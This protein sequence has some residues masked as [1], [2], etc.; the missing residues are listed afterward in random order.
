MY[1]VRSNTTRTVLINQKV[2]MLAGYLFLRFLNI[3]SIDPHTLFTALIP[4][5]EGGGEL[6]FADGTDDPFPG[7]FQGLSAQCEASQLLFHFPAQEK[8]RWSQI[9]RIGRMLNELDLSG[10]EPILDHC[11][12]VDWSVVP[13]EKP[14]LFRHFGPLLVDMLH[15]G[16]QGLGD[17]GCVPSGAPGDDVGVDQPLAVEESQHHLLGAAGLDFC[18]DG[19]RL[20]L[21]NPSL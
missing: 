17:V 16:V 4:A 1:G 8:V 5:A 12:S 7:S 6:F 3:A 13:V 21:W 11:S 15:E 19:S 9:R 18:F 2:C 10:G 14:L 20:P